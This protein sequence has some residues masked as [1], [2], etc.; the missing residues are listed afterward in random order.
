MCSSNVSINNGILSVRERWP[1]LSFRKVFTGFTEL[2]GVSIRTSTAEAAVPFTARAS[3]LARIGLAG[4]RWHWCR[5]DIH[6]VMEV[7]QGM[8]RILATLVFYLCFIFIYFFMFLCA[9][10]DFNESKCWD[11]FRLILG[12]PPPPPQIKQFKDVV[13]SCFPVI[14]KCNYFI[15]VQMWVCSLEKFHAGPKTRCWM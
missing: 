6:S 1:T 14:I 15:S 5:Q 9:M 11:P 13:I 3:V 4:R 8:Q 2:P 10:L 7:E 12:N